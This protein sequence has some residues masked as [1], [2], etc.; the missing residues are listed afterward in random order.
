[1][2]LSDAVGVVGKKPEW[3]GVHDDGGACG[4]AEAVWAIKKPAQDP[5]SRP[6]EWM[7]NRVLVL[8]YCA[9]VP[10]ASLL[11]RDWARP[12]VCPR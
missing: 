6:N 5:L 11:A 7:N 2:C 8:D 12:Q 10:C 3:R 4:S 1:V 9:D